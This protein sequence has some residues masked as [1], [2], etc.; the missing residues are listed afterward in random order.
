MRALRAFTVVVL[1]LGLIAAACGGGGGSGS[2]SP[3]QAKAK[4]TAN[5]QKFF[6]PSVPV[7]QKK[8]IIQNYDK[9]LPTLKSQTTNPQAAGI[10]AKVNDVTLQGDKQAAV[11][12]DIVSA[13]DGTALLPGASGTAVK[14]GNNWEVSQ[15]TFCQLIK[16]SS[17]N[18]QC[19]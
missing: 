10:K 11:K 14:E 16:L 4:I 19:G 9:L 17:P 1:G 3:A 13:K 6:D 2:Q 15:A 18:A 7:E 12:Y 5:W 8:D